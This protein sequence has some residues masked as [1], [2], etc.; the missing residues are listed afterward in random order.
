MDIQRTEQE[1][2]HGFGKGSYFLRES[3]P[4]GILERHFHWT[5]EAVREMF[6]ENQ[7][8]WD[9]I[10]EKAREYLRSC[11]PGGARKI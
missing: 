4:A 3:T 2:S 5:P 7:L 9:K 8:I 11:Y 1:V 6:T 10:P